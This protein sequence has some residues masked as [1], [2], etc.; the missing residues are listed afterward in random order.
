MLLAKM[1]LKSIEHMWRI[2]SME[3]IILIITW[4]D[5]IGEKRLLFKINKPILFESKNGLK[6]TPNFIYSKSRWH[7][8]FNIRNECSI[9]F[10]NFLLFCV[11][12][13]AEY[14]EKG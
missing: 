9:D 13:Y 1:S 14:L 2:Y 8:K 12:T 4:I 6:V 7:F 11:Q 10:R 5:L 3:P